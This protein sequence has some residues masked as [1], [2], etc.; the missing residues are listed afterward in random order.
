[1]ALKLH[2]DVFRRLAN[3]QPKSIPGRPSGAQRLQDANGVTVTLVQML[4]DYACH[5][6]GLEPGSSALVYI[7]GPPSGYLWFGET[8]EAGNG[9]EG[10]MYT[11]VRLAGH[12][13][14]FIYSAPPSPGHERGTL[15]FEGGEAVP[16][17]TPQVRVDISGTIASVFARELESMDLMFLSEKTQ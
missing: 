12:D 3:W 2:P 8:I 10:A 7:K 15:R 5:A 6:V 9:V 4:H 17:D 14:F 16:V 11:E 13:P 1:V